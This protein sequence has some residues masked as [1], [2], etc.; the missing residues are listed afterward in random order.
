M[1]V[2]AISEGYRLGS[3]TH[4]GRARGAAD[5][6][7]FPTPIGERFFFSYGKV[8]VYSHIGTSA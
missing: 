7:F 3:E 6:G 8:A 2:R 5:Y 4:A 1:C